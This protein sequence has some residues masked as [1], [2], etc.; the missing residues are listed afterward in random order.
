MRARLLALAAAAPLLFGMTFAATRV[1]S[2][3]PAA[4]MPSAT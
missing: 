2:A 3:S 1:A 4:P